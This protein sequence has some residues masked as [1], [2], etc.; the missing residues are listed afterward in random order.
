[1]FD[2]TQTQTQFWKRLSENVVKSKSKIVSE[3][4]HF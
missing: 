4:G 3:I 1:M 2:D